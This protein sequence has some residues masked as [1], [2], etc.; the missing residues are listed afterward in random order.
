[1][2]RRR[3]SVWDGVTWA[4]M[5]SWW[6]EDWLAS[7]ARSTR[8]RPSRAGRDALTTRLYHD[9]MGGELQELLRYGDRNSMAWSR[10]VR[11][12]YL[13]HRIA[14][15]AFALPPEYKLNRGETKVVLREAVRPLV[16][17]LVAERR[18]KLGYQ[19]PLSSWLWGPLRD[20]TMDRLEQAEADFGGLLAPGTRAR[21]GALGERASEAV[22]RPV[23]SLLTLVESSR[24]LRAVSAAASSAATSH[25]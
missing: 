7:F 6:H 3:H 14:E 1:V 21:F 15:H 2:R 23:F 8:P 4:E 22:A 18:D 5:A 17:R 19:A 11:Q 16:P 20:W 25:R 10:E 13:D 24:A 12:P 9:L